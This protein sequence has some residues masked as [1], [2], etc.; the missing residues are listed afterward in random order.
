MPH[1]I[2][3]LKIV[4]EQTI[5]ISVTT[6]LLLLHLVN[7]FGNLM[8]LSGIF[9]IIIGFSAA[10]DTANRNKHTDKERETTYN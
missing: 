8:G 2:I 5:D 9:I 10:R 7:F 4:F 1:Q 6:T 3:W